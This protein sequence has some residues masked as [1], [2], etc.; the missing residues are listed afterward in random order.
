MQHE[1]ATNPF[2]AIV[3]YFGR[4]LS[5][6]GLRAHA[7]ESTAVPRHVK[8]PKRKLLDDEH[9]LLHT[10]SKDAL[11][12]HLV[13]QYRKQI[14]EACL[15]ASM[16]E[17]SRD[18]I[19]KKVIM[20]PI[21]LP[22]GHRF[23][24]ENLCYKILSAKPVVWKCPVPGCTQHANLQTVRMSSSLALKRD[25]QCEEQRRQACYDAK[26]KELLL[27]IQE[28]IKQALDAAVHKRPKRGH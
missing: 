19:S 28:D 21:L 22:C 12:K 15:K 25:I 27:E 7:A 24:R 13:E 1:Q 3:F 18:V 6:K 20:D 14:D 26:Y 9:V 17:W 23:D 10:A 8:M 2:T 5:I 11:V 16:P 4:I